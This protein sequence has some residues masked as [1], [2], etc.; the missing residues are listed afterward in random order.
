MTSRTKTI[1]GADFIR[2]ADGDPST[3]RR[4]E[5]YRQLDIAWLRSL[6]VPFRPD[7]WEGR[8]LLY[9][10]Q[11]KHYSNTRADRRYRSDRHAPAGF[12]IS[13]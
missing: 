6:I 8:A 10:P 7:P 12:E 3:H 5:V 2:L 1:E 11:L 13:E 9:A 4:V